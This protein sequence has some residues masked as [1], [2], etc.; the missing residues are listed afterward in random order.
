MSYVEFKSL[1]KKVNLKPK[2]VKEIVLEVNDRGL[3]GQ[4][5]SLSEMIDLKVFV[6][7]ESQVVNYNVTLN[8]NNNKPIK[9]YKVDEKGVVHEV[10]PE[11]KQIEADLGL[12]DE[13]VPTKEEQME[14]E[15]KVVD[16]FILADLAPKFDDFKLDMSALIKRQLN[17]ETYLKI[18]TELEMSSGK[19]VLLMD[20]YRKQVAPLAQKWWEWKESNATESS[21]DD[22]K[23]DPSEIESESEDEQ[24]EDP[25]PEGDDND[26]KDGAA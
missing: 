4:L 18:A 21:E 17:G 3:D 19:L 14:I 9:E 20:D 11:G 13:K 24:Q 25:Q 10:K 12:P 7:L 23:K 1:V 5:D 26:E 16:E 8:A 6:A 22:D 15:R 2:G